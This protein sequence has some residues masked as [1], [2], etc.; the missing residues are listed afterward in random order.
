MKLFALSIILF[1]IASE[2]C[3]AEKNNKDASSSAEI[4]LTF[5]VYSDAHIISGNSVLYSSLSKTRTSALVLIAGFI[6][7]FLAALAKNRLEENKKKE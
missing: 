4:P 2:I 7:S 6:A 1:V 3:I 5:S